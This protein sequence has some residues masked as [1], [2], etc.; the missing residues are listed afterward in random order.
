MLATADAGVFYPGSAPEQFPMGIPPSHTA[1]VRAEAALPM[2][3]AYREAT[4]ALGAGTSQCRSRPLV[5][6]RTAVTKTKGF[7]GVT[8]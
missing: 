2:P 5:E 4:T 7:H 3:R 6:F 1:S 8:G